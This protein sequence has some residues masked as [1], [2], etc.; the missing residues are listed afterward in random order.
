M[1]VGSELKRNSGAP[2]FA[3]GTDIV[4]GNLVTISGPWQVTSVQSVEEE[5]IGA[6]RASAPAHD[7]VD[8]RDIAEG[9]I[10]RAIAAAT[11]TAGNLVGFASNATIAG[12]SGVIQVTK[13]GPV[14]KGASL[15]KSTWSVGQSLETALPGNTFAYRVN[16]R[17]LSGL[18]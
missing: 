1:G 16:P 3:G 13:L 15:G 11:I 10:V 17:Q 14:S 6:A 5:V 7:P 9:G 8:V 12:A 4:G 2:L 18:S